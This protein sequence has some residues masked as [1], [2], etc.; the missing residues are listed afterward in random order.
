MCVRVC[1]ER[2]CL[3]VKSKQKLV[4][5]STASTWWSQGQ[6]GFCSAVCHGVSYQKMVC[7]R[8]LTGW[9]GHC[10]CAQQPLIPDLRIVEVKSCEQVRACTQRRKKHCNR[11]YCSKAVYSRSPG[12]TSNGK[13]RQTHMF[14]LKLQ[15]NLL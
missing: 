4:F 10:Y 12:D 7:G 13:W 11:L 5:Y 1:V 9:K 3:Q 2:L 15:E 8:S 6:A 14:F